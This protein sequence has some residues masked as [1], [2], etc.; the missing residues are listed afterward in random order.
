[1]S[2]L[3]FL[4]TLP[5]GGGVPRSY[6]SG[7]ALGGRVVALN[8]CSEVLMFVNLR[9]KSLGLISAEFRDEL[10]RVFGVRDSLQ[11]R[12]KL[13]V[14]CGL[15]LDSPDM[16]RHWGGRNPCSMQ[17]ESPEDGVRLVAAARARIATDRAESL[18][19]QV[20]AV[21]SDVLQVRQIAQD[22][23]ANT[24]AIETISASIMAEVSA[25]RQDI[26]NGAIM[27]A[28]QHQAIMAAGSVSDV[29][30]LQPPPELCCP[31]SKSIFCDPVLAPDGNTYD[32]DN[33]RAW[34]R[35]CRRHG[36]PETLP[37]SRMACDLQKLICNRALR[38][39]AEKW[40]RDHP[41]WSAIAVPFYHLC[42]IG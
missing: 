18:K 6:L 10:Y 1:M 19:D 12:A 32:R 13:C 42:C 2:D 24:T 11:R 14:H 30:S 23:L 40:V 20:E 5:F 8:V 22:T 39:L 33:L 27:A 4:S 34:F 3:E 16:L 25:L 7:V 28:P 21:H 17:L 37:L 9:D 29:S 15:Q 41:E 36:R 38:D 35:V 26:A 31:I